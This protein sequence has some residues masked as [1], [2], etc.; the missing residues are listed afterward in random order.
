M[1]KNIKDCIIIGSS[2]GLGAALVE[3]FLNNTDYN[4]IGIARTKLIEI[5]NHEK[6]ISSGRYQHINLDIASSQSR[7]IL[8]ATLATLS[9][10]PLCVIFNSAHVEK[11]VKEDKSIN[12]DIFDQINK[13]GINGLGNVLFA[14][15]PHFMKHGGIFVGI[16]SFW[17]I[18]PPLFL[19]WVAYPASK[20]YLNMTLRCL[21]VAWRNHVKVVTVNIGNIGGAE[22]AAKNAYPTWIVP[23][24]AMAAGKIVRT[25]TKEKMPAII[26]YPL[27]HYIIYLH[28][29]R[30][31]PEIVYSWAF[32]LYFNLA[33]KLKDDG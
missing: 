6:W 2:R 31:V 32:K 28:I 17:G 12:Y 15:E 21:K 10:T 22:N 13:V 1:N 25:V 20:A 33:S 9:P 11:D 8:R 16:S 19:P 30:F 18:V 7:E 23:T 5:K 3:E 27:L 24:Y 4:L 14:T 29:L 26:N